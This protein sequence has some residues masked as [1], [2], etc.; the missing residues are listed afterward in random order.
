MKKINVEVQCLCNKSR[1]IR[2]IEYLTLELFN[3]LVKHG[4]NRYSASFFDFQRERNN[5]EL[6]EEYFSNY[7]ILDLVE[8][9][10]CNSLDY[11]DVI[12]AWDSE[13][14]PAYANRDYEEYVN[15]G[16]DIYYFPQ[17]VTLPANLPFGKTIVT[18]CDILHLKN[19]QARKFHPKASEQIKRIIDYIA[20]REDIFITAISEATK[21]DLVEYIG[22]DPK[23][24]E[25]V[26]LAYNKKLFWPQTDENV[27]KEMGIDKPYVLY[28]GGLDAH[29]GLDVLCKA[30]DLLNR[31]D[32]KLVLAG[33]RCKWYDIDS[34]INAMRQK[35]NVIMPGYVSDEQKRVLM[36]MA[37]V[38]VFPSY[39][40]GFGLP[41][42]EAM[43]CGAPVISTNVTSLPEVGGNAAVYIN[44]GDSEMLRDK[45]EMILSD[46]GLK[47]DIRKRSLSRAQEFSWDNTA[48]N[49]ERVFEQYAAYQG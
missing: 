42:I 14:Q 15:A 49:M 31:Q 37:E 22:I 29:K 26:T 46:N 35:D 4:N 24:I 43:A 12:R 30:Y 27:L 9:H 47:E 21:K 44:P 40:E 10:E 34:V 19:E 45:L 36:S 33:G 1:Q 23:R 38:F 41:V 32:V 8:M 7:G 3:T 28:L 6:L 17:T 20:G 48:K 39:F 18:V 2:G 25:A 5:R 16:A 13:E 11:R